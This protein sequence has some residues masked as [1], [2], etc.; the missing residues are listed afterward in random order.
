MEIHV[1]TVDSC[2][3]CHGSFCCRCIV[4]NIGRSMPSFFK[5]IDGLD[6]L[7]HNPFLPLHE[8]LLKSSTPVEFYTCARLDLNTGRCEIYE[9]RPECCKSF[10]S[11]HDHDLLDFTFTA[12]WCLFRQ[13][14]AILRGDDY[15]T[16]KLVECLAYYSDPTIERGDF[17]PAGTLDSCY[18][19]SRYF[20]N[21]RLML[22]LP[23]VFLEDTNDFFLMEV[24]SAYQVHFAVAFGRMDIR[25]NIAR[26][27]FQKIALLCYKYGVNP[28][29]FMNIAKLYGQTHT[30]VKTDLPFPTYLVGSE[31]QSFLVSRL[32]RI[33][34]LAI[35][36][37]KKC[38]G[39]MCV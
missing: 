27:A 25:L 6:A 15:E 2:E 22:S 17:T 16:R 21:R 31:F 29:Q 3:S 24:F 14:Q 4:V 5:K 7:G 1:L 34:D 8:L 33:R 37:Y 19:Y 18:R 23:L 10:P 9:G 39:D 11:M 28:V 12:P 13:K 26:K 20:L 32:D 35:K 36:E 38:E 30:N